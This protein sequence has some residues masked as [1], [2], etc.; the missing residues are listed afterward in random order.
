[1]R[2]G[3]TG[4]LLCVLALLLGVA[5]AGAI[6]TVTISATP[7]ATVGAMEGQRIT[8]TASASNLPPGTQLVR[9]RFTVNKMSDNSIVADSVPGSPQGEQWPTQGSWA[10]V[11]PVGSAA[12]GPYK[13]CVVARP[14]TPS[15]GLPG[16][17][18]CIENYRIRP[19]PPRRADRPG[20][21]DTTVPT[22]RLLPLTVNLIPK[23]PACVVV[24]RSVTLS[25]VPSAPPG[26][27]EQYKYAFYVQTQ[28]IGPG[29]PTIDSRGP[30]TGT[31]WESRP[32]NTLGDYTLG[33]QL[34]RQDA[35]GQN[36][37][38]PTKEIRDYHVRQTCP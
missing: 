21:I 14:F 3:M 4:T 38:T 1:M 10:W 9:Y 20:A 13:L 36:L 8:M 26:A 25:G 16:Q 29:S 11:P 23:P 34:Y 28:A 35:Q 30:E 5:P 15:Q 22:R 33:V 6:H 17:I 37:E 2:R 18:A 7:P 12:A 32:I 31:S 19:Q 27:G 24:G